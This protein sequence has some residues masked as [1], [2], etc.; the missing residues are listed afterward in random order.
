MTRI[1][2]LHLAFDFQVESAGGGVSRFAMD[3][4][5]ALDRKN[6]SPAICG[7]WNRGTELEQRHL[8]EMQED[9]IQAFTAA[10]WNADHPYESFRRAQANL[11]AYLGNHP[12]Q[13]VHSHSEFSDVAALLAKF[14]RHVP[15]ILRSVHYGYQYEWRNRPLRRLLLTNFLYP[16]FYDQEIGISRDIQVRLD[17]RPAARILGK[18]SLY[19]PNAIN[20]ERFNQQMGD[21]L[22]LRRQLGLP[23]QQLIIGSV[24]RLSEQ[25]DYQTLVRAAANVRQNYPNAYFVHVGDGEQRQELETLAT[26]LGLTGEFIFLG[27]QGEIEKYLAAM[28]LFVSSSLWEGLPTVILESMASGVPVVATD[29]PGTRDLIEPGV[30]GWLAPPGNAPAL[31]QKI[32]EALHSPELRASFAE[33]SRRI[34]SRYSMRSVAEQHGELYIQLYTRKSTGI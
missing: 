16:L 25:K 31:A 10:P 32:I 33:Q 26:D 21:K 20:L 11:L 8:Q 29:I 17:A 3:L 5:R 7:L 14:R 13:I 23:I 2:V 1:R 9:G 27:Q 22:E 34:A 19:L 15:V 30:N 24:G 18:K 12:T 4:C 6:F 28:D